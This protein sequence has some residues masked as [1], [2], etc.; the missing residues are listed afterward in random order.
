M[1]SRG[2]S[3]N[4]TTRPRFELISFTLFRQLDAL[5]QDVYTDRSWPAFAASLVNVERLA[6]HP[7]KQALP[8][9]SGCL[10]GW[11]RTE[12]GSLRHAANV[13]RVCAVEGDYD[14][15]RVT[16]DEAR[17]L[18]DAAGIE[19]LLYTTPSHRADAP[20]WRVIAPL[21]EPALPAQR[22][23]YV[24]RLNRALHGVLARESFTLSQSFYVGRVQGAPYQAAHI[25][26]Y[27]CIDEAADIE[28]LLCQLGANGEQTALDLVA[29]SDDELRALFVRAEH[30]HHAMLTLSGRW[31][32]AGRTFSD[33]HH[34]LLQLLD[35]SPDRDS[36]HWQARRKEVPS[37]ARSAI[38]KCSDVRT[39]LSAGGKLLAEARTWN[40]PAERPWPEPPDPAVYQGLAG[41][42]VAAIKPD[43]EADPCAVLLHLLV[44]FGALAGRGA[45][46]YVE[47]VRHYPNLFACV[48]GDTSKARKGTA[49]ARLRQILAEIPAM[50]RIVSGLASGEGMKFAVRDDDAVKDKRLLVVESEFASTLRVAKRDGSTLSPTVRD[51]WDT[52]CLQT[53]TKHDPIVA[54][55]AHIAIMAHITCEE[56]RRELTDTD[57]CNGFANRFLLCCA[58]RSQL[59]PFGGAQLSAE[60]LKGFASELSKAAQAAHDTSRRIEM[61]PEA[62][63]FWR[64]QYAELSDGGSG[65]FG[66]ATARAEAHCVRLALVYALLDSSTVI[67]LPHLL[68][69]L[70]LWRYC[71]RS[72][73]YVWGDA[74][75]D[76]IA[77]EIRRALAGAPAGLDRTDLQAH[78][79]RHQSSARIGAALALLRECGTA[80]VEL[81]DTGGRRREVW[82]LTAKE[83]N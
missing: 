72:V 38:E 61:D 52:G 5:D 62:A 37:I 71:E 81:Q 55:N 63:R 74:L 6:P 8:L 49:W 26:G 46:Y 76:E 75:G 64:E 54:T 42:I 32:S 22:E 14:G 35:S 44:G 4:G 36:E 25:V 33:I 24:A 17:A 16:L 21:S 10:F 27:R 67:T 11:Q 60:V 56:L 50:P 68:A 43:T 29:L 20:R 19:A 15:G 12:K 59:L 45:Y 41:R 53:L 57:L 65:L 18:L 39:Q 82:K 2:N 51:A 77:D 58:R 83:A 66:A 47:G 7:H 78:F 3:M 13:L 34:E 30:R 69:A 1:R 23:V 48:V 73:R 28:P 80:E 40:P 31:A 70:A 9:F 79:H